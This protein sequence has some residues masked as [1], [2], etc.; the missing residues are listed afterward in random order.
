MSKTIQK[1]VVFCAGPT[2]TTTELAFAAEINKVLNEHGYTPV[3]CRTQFSG[4]LSDEEKGLAQLALDVYRLINVAES[5]VVNLNGR[6]PDP[7]SVWLSSL[8]YAHGLK[9]ILYK[10]DH[11][12]KFFGMDNSMISGLGDF[13]CAN[14]LI[15]IPY[16]LRSVQISGDA[17]SMTAPYLNILRQAGEKIQQFIDKKSRG[18]QMYES[19]IQEIVAEISASFHSKS[20]NAKTSSGRVYCSGA[21]FNPEEIRTMNSISLVL[22]NAG[23]KTFLPQRDGV[24]AFLMNGASNV[25]LNSFPF[26][27]AHSFFHKTV[28]R[29]DIYE[30]MLGCDAFVINLNGVMPDEG[31]VVEWALAFSA[32]KPVVVFCDDVRRFSESGPLSALASLALSSEK[33]MDLPGAIESVVQSTP[34]FKFDQSRHRYLDRSLKSGAR[35]GQFVN[36]IKSLKPDNNMWEL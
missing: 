31:A 10:N 30:V 36:R 13:R 34:F 4:A 23:W 28:F 8:A 19:E 32:G 33:I 12:A 9:P 2:Y 16:Y 6:V 24:E 26:R 21:L 1:N 5:F 14:K 11:R 29:L 35:I 3:W 7:Y 15:K 17:G 27:L 20:N 22:E 25:L 18:G